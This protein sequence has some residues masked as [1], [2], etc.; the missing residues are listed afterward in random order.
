MANGKTYTWLLPAFSIHAFKVSSQKLQ[1]R[2]KRGKE[3]LNRGPELN[4]NL[5]ASLLYVLCSTR[6][7]AN[8]PERTY[9]YAVR[10]EHVEVFFQCA[11]GLRAC[12]C[13]AWCIFIW[14]FSCIRLLQFS[15]NI[16]RERMK[17][18][19]RF[20]LRRLL[21]LAATAPRTAHRRC[22]EL[23]QNCEYTNEYKMTIVSRR[24]T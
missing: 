15:L 4:S 2:R 20:T 11:C 12:V 6:S 10:C 19:I 14:L 13:C 3:R 21:C 9:L 18:L 23:I 8:V 5:P 24:G 7:K 1:I 16:F 17:L 22:Y